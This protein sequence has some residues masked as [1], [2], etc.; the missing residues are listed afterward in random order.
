MHKKGMLLIA[1]MVISTGLLSGC[2]GNPFDP[3]TKFVGT[4]KDSSGMVVLVFFSDKTVNSPVSG[5][6][7][8]Y[9]IKDGKLVITGAEG[10]SI[11]NYS[12]SNDDTTLTLVPPQ[13]T[14]GQIVLTKQ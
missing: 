4:W 8:T 7:G 10:E 3:A 13:V 2:T 14:M 6:H 12:F 9:E 11:Y 5:E 1:V